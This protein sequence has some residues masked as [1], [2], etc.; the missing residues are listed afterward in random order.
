MLET[1][2][3]VRVA[4]PYR[5]L[6]EDGDETRAWIVAQN[7][8]TDAALAEI[9]GRQQMR[10]RVT[11]LLR[12][13]KVSLPYRGGD[14]YFW[15]YHDG[16]KEQRVVMT[17]HS[18]EGPARVLVDA[19]QISSD[20]RFAFAGFSPSDDGKRLA[21]GLAAGG[22]D[23]TTW[24]LRD[25]ATGADLPEVL[26]H[27]KYYRPQFTRDGSAIIYSRFP[28]PPEGQQIKAQD[29]HHKVYLHRLGT[30]VDRDVVLFE[31]PDQPTWQF[32]PQVTRDGRYLVIT[33]GDGQVGDS[34]REQVALIDL[35]R[36]RKKPV[37]LVDR[38][39]EEYLLVGND[40]PILFFKTTFGAAKKRIVAIDVRAPERDRWKEIVPEGASAIQS[41]SLVGR[42]IFVTT[43]V[44]AHAMVAAYDLEGKKLRDVALPGMGAV[45]GFHGGPRDRETTFLFTGFTVPGTVHRYDLETGATRT[46]KAPR[47]P[48]DPTLFETRQ[49]FFPSKDGTKVPMF[50]TGRKALPLDGQNPAIMTGYG[51]GGISST[52]YFSPSMIAWLERGGL[53]VLVN[54]RG[55][56]EYGTAWHH[57]ATRERRQVGVDDFRRRGGVAGELE[58]HLEPEAGGDR[59]LRRGLAGGGGDGPA[60]G[61]VRCG[62]AGGRR[63]RHDALPSVRAGGGLAGGHG[64]TRRSLAGQGPA[65]PVS[66]AQRS[67]RGGLSPGCS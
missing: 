20:G 52:P 59:L 62:G 63:A 15:T 3:G 22:G 32:D 64:R 37:M 42:Q 56:G 6:E 53:F 10:D 13:E 25:V 46:W 43:L 24:R 11:D 5:W 51:F 1:R 9:E 61:A 44:D 23:W 39:E 27:V 14:R 54:I 35:D 47:V 29:R 16:M 2:H 26:E 48:F 34:S 18:L 21:Y 4:D 38:Y 36:P 60:A 67:T 40:G 30:P 50:I 58:T 49:V 33:I 55:G 28:P 45:F 66:A 8:A 57:A 12:H 17:A 19:N 65:R 31:R 41:A 7:Q